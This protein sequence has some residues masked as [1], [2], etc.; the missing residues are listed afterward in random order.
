MARE[1]LAGWGVPVAEG[2]TE[3][4]LLADPSIRHAAYEQG[5]PTEDE[6]CRIG[7]AR[8]FPGARQ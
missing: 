5:R 3:S 1:V 8:F 2:R 6:A 7:D 4:D